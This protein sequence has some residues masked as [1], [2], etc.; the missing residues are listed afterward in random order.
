[1]QIDIKSIVVHKLI[2]KF[3]VCLT[4]VQIVSLV[5]LTYRQT[6]LPSTPRSLHVQ[7]LKIHFSNLHR[8][9]FSLLFV[10][11]DIMSKSGS[12]F[13][14]LISKFRSRIE[15]A[16]QGSPKERQERIDYKR[17]ILACTQHKLIREA[18]EGVALPTMPS[19]TV[20]ESNFQ[21]GHVS[22]EDYYLNK[23]ISH[24]ES[25]KADE[26][27]TEELKQELQE[28]LEP[29][30]LGIF[31]AFRTA[32]MVL[33]A[34]HGGAMEGT[35]M[36]QK[37]FQERMA[38][39]CKPF[40]V[41]ELVEIQKRLVSA[42]E[43]KP[44]GDEQFKPS[45]LFYMRKHEEIEALLKNLETNTSDMTSGDLEQIVQL[46]KG[47]IIKTALDYSV[48]SLPS[49][50]PRG[51]RGLFL[52][53]TASIGSIVAFIPGKVWPREYLTDAQLVEREFSV[54]PNH[55][56]SMRHDGFLVDSRGV[57]HF[58]PPMTG[59][60]VFALGHACNHP[61]PGGESN[62]LAAPF[63][64]MD[65]L[66]EDWGSY[67]P[68][69]YAKPPQLLGSRVM[70]IGVRMQSLVLVA[71]RNLMNEELLL[72]YRLNPR[73]KHPSWY[74]PCDSIEELHRAWSKQ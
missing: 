39:I 34:S 62:V 74:T 58:V 20:D 59:R 10:E 69:T 65:T 9:R 52:D 19:A 38:H 37:A 35:A 16:A 13:Q 64:F 2:F 41:K 43:A 30:V 5:E 12:L 42:M 50:I 21:T 11:F 22:E 33:D 45:I 72:N 71:R 55:E 70:H 54:D 31:E 53:G 63:N 40:L 23:A 56:M 8:L 24:L 48:I 27:N 6:I 17:L 3:F 67:I 15:L 46:A 29:Q 4:F 68:N 1:L 73:G 18:A 44:Q 60:N 36:G 47:S 26:L 51:G 32:E 14:R 61:S 66:G 49:T 25:K 28:I 7:N 57:S